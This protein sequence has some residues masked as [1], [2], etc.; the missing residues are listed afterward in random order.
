MSTAVLIDWVLGLSRR[1]KRL[2]AL[3]FD[4]FCCGLSVL[5]AFYLRLGVWPSIDAIVAVPALVSIAIALPIFVLFGLYRAIFRYIGWSAILAIIR[6]IALYSF[7]FVAIYTIF[8]VANVPRTVGL[9]QPIILFLLIASSRM[10]VRLFLAERY[11]DLWRKNSLPRVII[12]GAGSSGRQLASAIR[13]SN[14]M[15]V[16]GFVD[17][18]AELWQSTI[19]G[20]PVHKPSAVESLVSRHT[21]SDVLLAMPSASRARRNEIV[22]QMR[23]LNL[24]VRTLPGLLDIARGKVSVTDLRTVQIEDLLGRP[25]VKPDY[26]LVG[27]SVGGATILVTG[28]GGSIGG[29]LCRQIILNHPG[30]LL[31]VDSSEFNLYSIH[32]ELMEIATNNGIDGEVIV[33]LLAS[34]IDDRRMTEIFAAWRPSTVFHAAA[35][36]HVPLVEHN[37]VEGVR[38]NAIGTYETARLAQRYST[39]RF[40]LISTDKAV[41]PTNI[42]GASK[43]LA[44]MML[45][46]M[47]DAGGATRFSMVR[48]GNVLGSSGSVVPLFRRQLAAGGPVT[49]T[50]PEMTRYFM[51]IP[52]AAQL[53]LHAGAMTS[54]GEVYVLDMGEPVL[55]IDLARNIIEL[56]GLSVRDCENPDGDIEIRVVGLRPGEKLYE[57]LLIGDNPEP[58]SHPRICRA[59]ERFE[60]WPQLMPRLAELQ[61][62]IAAGDARE[63]QRILGSIVT[64]YRPN[65]PMVDWIACA[66]NTSTGFDHK[67]AIKLAATSA[68]P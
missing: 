23:E 36:K 34:V 47:N 33:P 2:I 67:A 31:L 6:A 61:R 66:S 52:E 59:N 51:T 60:P 15:K 63:T 54:G 26:D 68:G 65:S 10:I 46:A 7:A 17:D 56:S 11:A 45:Q 8:G 49:V 18:D 41:R 40:I 12:Y 57:E 21:V 13:A 20:V 43:R 9:I 30:R 62:A 39:S 24:E 44:E 27:D 38:N 29:E 14:E 37:I 1:A 55:I 3:S 64:E 4:S 58:T 48:F 42:M 22:R 50:H 5:L 35:F 16:V 53:V 19:D 32:H 28:A 25:P